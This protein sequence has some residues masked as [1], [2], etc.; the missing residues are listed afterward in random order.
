MHDHLLYTS[1]KRCVISLLA[2]LLRRNVACK[3][4]MF[5]ALSAASRSFLGLNSCLLRRHLHFSSFA[6][7]LLQRHKMPAAAFAKPD[8]AGSRTLRDY[9]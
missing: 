1:Q 9:F 5:E 3:W 7:G 4:E 8:D 6:Q 2:A